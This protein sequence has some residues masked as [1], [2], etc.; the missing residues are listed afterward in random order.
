[1]PGASCVETPH[2]HGTGTSRHQMLGA[3][4]MHPAQRAGLPVMPEPRVKQDGPE[5][6]AGARRAAQ[7][8]R[9]KRRQDHPHLTW[10]GTAD[11]RSATA[12]PLQVLH[13]HHLH[14]ILGVKE[15]AQADVCEQVAVAEPAGRVTDDDREASETGLRHR[16]RCV[17]NVPRTEAHADLRINFLAC[18]EW[19]QDTVQPCS[20]LTDLRVHQGTV[21]PRMR[22][23]RARWRSAHEP[24]QTLKHQG[25][26]FAHNFGR[27]IYRCLSQRKTVRQR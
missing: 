18:W 21:Y 19:D 7:R 3:A 20:W 6:N 12:P 15:G 24:F 16:C 8:V 5:Q 14:D 4:L 11:G 10:S 1:M 27:S 22:G 26:H 9:A 13:D 25:D 23:G 2:R 17:R